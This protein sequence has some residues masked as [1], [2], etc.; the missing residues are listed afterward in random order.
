MGRLPG[1]GDSCSALKEEGGGWERHSR[2]VTGSAE[3]SGATVG[4]LV[5]PEP[6]GEGGGINA[7]ARPQS[8][9]RN[10]GS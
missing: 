6:E 1:G 5:G 8:G 4:S 7:G 9:N 10:S 3:S 2:H